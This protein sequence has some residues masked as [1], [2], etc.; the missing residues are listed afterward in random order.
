MSLLVVWA[1]S[2]AR[3]CYD[4]SRGWAAEY[5]STRSAGARAWGRYVAQDDVRGG[6][7]EAYDARA[8]ALVSP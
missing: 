7:I 4:A 2:R 3:A 5:L 6:A 8:R 1:V